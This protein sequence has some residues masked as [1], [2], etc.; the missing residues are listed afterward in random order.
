M[1][2]TEIYKSTNELRVNLKVI[3]EKEEH[4]KGAKSMQPLQRLIY[5]PMKKDKKIVTRSDK[6]ICV[7]MSAVWCANVIKGGNDTGGTT[8][9]EKEKA[10][11]PI[12]GRAHF[13]QA[14]WEQIFRKQ[15]GLER[16]TDWHRPPQKTFP[17]TAHR[18][19]EELME[20][21]AFLEGVGMGVTV[22]V[23]AKVQ[24]DRTDIDEMLLFSK[25]ATLMIFCPGHCIAVN[26]SATGSG[27]GLRKNNYIFDPDQGMYRYADADL[28]DLDISAEF[29]MSNKYAPPPEDPDDEPWD[30]PADM[31]MRW[32]YLRIGP[33]A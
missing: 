11:K 3:L 5:P 6:G 14:R 8:I 24:L 17:K 15:W 12:E 16:P 23:P 19:M 7:G 9:E 1:I 27:E 31:P 21:K 30:D 18:V 10:T 32:N 4:I 25:D 33:V 22:T 2:G 29:T 20:F 13:I 26:R 28:L